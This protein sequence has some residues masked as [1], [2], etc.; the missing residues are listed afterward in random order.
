MKDGCSLGPPASVV[1]DQR[2][3]REIFQKKKHAF[4]LQA[5]L[6]VVKI[7]K[8]LFY[9]KRLLR[10]L[11]AEH[12]PIGLHSMSGNQHEINVFMH[13][14]THSHTYTHTHTHT[15]THA[16]TNAHTHTHTYRHTQTHADTHTH[17]EIRTHKRRH[18]HTH[19]HTLK[20]RNQWLT[21][22]EV[23]V[24]VLFAGGAPGIQTGVLL[25]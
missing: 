14:F 2:Q 11:N 18:T 25:N 10:H 7:L 23:L 8:S 17:A 6:I 13:T 3:A 22:L 5:V 16:R 21:E 19:T 1:L 4:E 15:H 20:S 24:S 9:I 12:M